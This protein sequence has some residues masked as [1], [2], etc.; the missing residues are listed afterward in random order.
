MKYQDHHAS[1]KSGKSLPSRG[2]WIEIFS[3]STTASVTRGSLPSRGAWI[4]IGSPETPRT[5]CRCRSPRGERGLKFDD[6]GLVGLGRVSLPSRGAWIEI[7]YRLTGEAAQ[8]VAPL[9][10]SVD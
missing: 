7:Y 10:G 2:A 4:E 1:A 8:T 6:F 5:G 3:D 9:A